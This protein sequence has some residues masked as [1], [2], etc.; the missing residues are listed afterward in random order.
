MEEKYLIELDK[1]IGKKVEPSDDYLKWKKEEEEILATSGKEY[2]I[3]T[4]EYNK[5]MEE[6][7]NL[8]YNFG[9]GKL[10][11]IDKIIKLFNKYLFTSDLSDVNIQKNISIF[12]YIKI[13]D[14]Y[15]EFLSDN[16]YTYSGEYSNLFKDKKRITTNKIQKEIH[17]L[18]KLYKIAIVSNEDDYFNKY[19]Y[20][21]PD[22]QQKLIKYFDPF[23][24]NFIK[25]L[26]KLNNII[27]TKKYNEFL[28]YKLLEYKMDKELFEFLEE[29]PE[30]F[31]GY[32]IEHVYD[33]NSARIVFEILNNKVNKINNK[34]LQL[35]YYYNEILSIISKSNDSFFKNVFDKIKFNNIENKI[36]IFEKV[37]MFIELEDLLFKELEI[38]GTWCYCQSP[39]TYNSIFEK[40]RTFNGTKKVKE[41]N[42]F[43]FI[44]DENETV[45]FTD[46]ITINLD[47]IS[48]NSI[49]I[50]SIIFSDEIEEKFNFSSSTEE[51]VFDENSND[52]VYKYITN[53]YQTENRL[54]LLFEEIKNN[55]L[56]LDN[57]L[58]VI[59]NWIELFNGINNIDLL[60]KK[61]EETMQI[62][63]LNET[64][65]YLYSYDDSLEY[66][67][68]EA[69]KMLYEDLISVNSIYANYLDELKKFTKVK[70]ALLSASYIWNI[71]NKLQSKELD[72]N[73]I[74]YTPIVANYFKAVE[75]L[76]YRK[77]RDKYQQLTNK[78]FNLRKPYS[79][80]GKTI[81]LL[82]NNDNEITLG[83]MIK[84]LKREDKIINNQIDK[85]AFV[86]NLE[87]WVKDVRNSHFHKDLIVSKAKAF[88]FKYR[89]IFIIIEILKSI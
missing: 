59:K 76:L 32:V 3:D 44:N 24:Q 36:D 28:L 81:N 1:M 87:I 57:D 48:Q 19:I 4:I 33:Y 51:T 56:S 89:T 22:L 20:N 18:Y 50:N 58:P 46:N 12:N 65:K 73:G 26:I 41:E 85:N 79:V 52:F 77:I 84:Y 38:Q 78:G 6:Y 21:I 70:K 63:E 42:L 64:K 7:N 71:Y 11:R 14:M 86:E 61:S 5:F 62:F 67:T 23:S 27:N 53:D 40:Y 47:N 74:D 9:Y 80:I 69:E 34:K 35:D 82:D 88:D 75:L 49:D 66:N 13:A 83:E 54:R 60:L 39:N 17:K 2:S 25:L 43:Y 15:L 16:Y 68:V 10:Y 8:N 72:K 30:N 45:D 37:D 55:F 29:N 31:N